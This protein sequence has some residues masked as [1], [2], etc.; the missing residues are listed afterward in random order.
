[1]AP[2]SARWPLLLLAALLLAPAAQGA[3]ATVR[4]AAEGGA[5]NGA[6]TV[7]PSAG[8]APDALLLWVPRDARLQS[9]TVDGQPAAWRA[10]GAS[11]LRVE[12]PPGGAEATARWD[13][14][15]QGTTVASVVAPQAYDALTLVV[16]PD[17]ERVPTSPAG[18]FA[19]EGDAYVL[20]LEGVEEGAAIPLRVVDADRVGELPLLLTVAGLALVVLAAGFAWHALRPPLGGRAP[21]RF[22]EHLGELQARLL[23]PAV[24]FALLN[25]LYFTAGLREASWRGIPLVAPTFG[26]DGSVAARAFDAFA[27]RLVPAG[28]QLV[29]LRP[30]DAVLA[31]VETALFLSFAT[32]LPLLVYELAVFLG[33]A[34]VERERRVALTVLPLVTGLFLLGT[35][36]AYLVTAPLMIRTLYA[37]APAVGAAPLLAVNDL[38]SFALLVIVAFGLA[39]E[40]PV[41]MYAV[42]RLRLARARTFARYFRHA[43]LVIVVLAGVITPDP[44]VVSQLLLAVPLVGLYALGI[45]TAYAGERRAGAPA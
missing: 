14:P 27:E 45:A 19:R 7:E 31:Q 30:A 38:V 41:V 25:V 21:E 43:V 4:L 34:L 11:A 22:T 16:E 29:V 42:A 35:M 23:P 40:L 20:R 39:F 37:Y 18:E 13:L 28:V 8:E 15:A 5:W 24:A 33:P 6:S 32:A 10:A 26:V 9:V 2:L 3:A 44:S 36:L 1:M 12:L 17:G